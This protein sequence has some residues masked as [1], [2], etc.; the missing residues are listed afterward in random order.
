MK[1]V[2]TRWQRMQPHHPLPNKVP[3]A[4]SVA[5]LEAQS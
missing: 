5:L 2:L 4:Q 1:Q 3:E